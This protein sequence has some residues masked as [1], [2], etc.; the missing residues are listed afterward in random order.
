MKQKG[1]EVFD[2]VETM[3]RIKDRLSKKYAASPDEQE[4]DLEKIRK[5]YGIRS[6]KKAPA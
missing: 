2:A 5:K 6:K 4:K 1:N 3:R